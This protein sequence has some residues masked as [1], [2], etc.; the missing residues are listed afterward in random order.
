MRKLLRVLSLLI[1][2]SLIVL[3]IVFYE[4]IEEWWGFTDGLITIISFSGIVITLFYTIDIRVYFFVHKLLM[5]FKF[6]HTNWLFS[7]N[8]ITHKSEE[9]TIN[10]LKKYFLTT[11]SIIKSIEHNRI[12]VLWKNKFLISIR[13][14]N[15]DGDNIV[16]I[17]TSKITV[18]SKQNNNQI[19][20]LISILE[21]IEGV[22][23]SDSDSKKTYEIDIEYTK[24]SPYYGYWIRKLPEQSVYDFNCKLRIANE[25]DEIVSVNKNHVIIRAF[26]FTKLFDL[27]KKYISL[28]ATG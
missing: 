27:T 12:E 28:Q 7:A 22:I 8:Y 11:E 24:T 17:F 25:K 3:Y 23:Q 10:K 9:E 1:P 2:I 5:I 19:S 15:K 20:E 18:P 6:D 26:Q 16:Y 13:M 4:K 14:D 21:S